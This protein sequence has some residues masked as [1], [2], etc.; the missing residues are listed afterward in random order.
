M[1]QK[2]H[3]NSP[4]YHSIMYNDHFQHSFELN[5]AKAT[6]ELQ[7]SNL[8][9]F[10]TTITNCSMEAVCDLDHTGIIDYL[11]CEV[12]RRMEQVGSL[13]FADTRCMVFAISTRQ[14]THCTV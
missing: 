6:A 9:E 3:F 11:R 10:C 4:N 14:V 12:Q 2:V 8:R 1:I 5:E 13:P 7:T